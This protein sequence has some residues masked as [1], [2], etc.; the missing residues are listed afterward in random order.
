MEISL[1][2]AAV[3]QTEQQRNDYENVLKKELQY[4]RNATSIWY[5]M[6][7]TTKQL[8]ISRQ[9]GNKLIRSLGMVTRS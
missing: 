4:M 6:K 7:C 5:V 2:Q 8:K 1:T 3:E 9:L